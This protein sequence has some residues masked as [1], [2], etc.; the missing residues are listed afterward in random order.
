MMTAARLDRATLKK[1]DALDGLY[2]PNEGLR[3]A[4]LAA[5]VDPAHA[6]VEVGS[7][8]GKSTCY[9]AA[10]AQ[11]GR[12]A[13]VY[14][15]DLWTDG[16]KNGFVRK[17]K[18]RKLRHIHYDSP[19]TLKTFRRQITLMGLA[20]AVTAYKASSLHVAKTWNQTVGLLHVDGNHNTDAAVADFR[21]FERFI[22]A[23]GWVAFHDYHLLRVK[24]AV[25]LTVGAS[26]EWVDIATHSRV[27][28]ARRR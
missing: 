9:L 3:L 16:P 10:G 6:I 14:A 4:T 17:Y 18:S 5:E 27:L 19:E 7:Y 1:L 28:S 25:E 2:W 8:R 15:I 20:D 13:H 12:G 24:K 21:A 22:P 26:D 11:S 23:G